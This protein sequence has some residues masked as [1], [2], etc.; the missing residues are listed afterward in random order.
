MR[1]FTW[2]PI[3]A[4]PLPHCRLLHLYAVIPPSFQPPPNLLQHPL[5]RMELRQIGR[6]IY[7]PQP[8]LRYRLRFVKGRMI[9]YHVPHACRLPRPEHLGHL[10]PL[11]PSHPVPSPGAPSSDPRLTP[12]TPTYTSVLHAIST[13]LPASSIPAVPVPR[14]PAA[15][16]LRTPPLPLAVAPPPARR[17]IALFPR[18]LRLRIRF[19]RHWLWYLLPIAPAPKLGV[20]LLVRNRPTQLPPTLR[21]RLPYRPKLPSRYRLPHP[22]LLLLR[23]YLWPHSL[24]SSIPPASYHFTHRYPH[25][26]FHPLQSLPSSRHPQRLPSLGYPS[27][28]LLCL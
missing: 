6:L 17:P 21:H 9:P 7:P 22:P 20:Q 28:Y 8:D 16:H 18:L 11:H 23:P 25:H 27:L 19:L 13:S 15:S 26:L 1:P 12:N 5:R 4:A 24:T 3:F 2:P 10:N 14:A